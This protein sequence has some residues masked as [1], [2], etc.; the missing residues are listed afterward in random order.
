[1]EPT[2]Q[3]Q[4]ILGVPVMPQLPARLAF[5]QGKMWHAILS[6]PT[7]AV[8]ADTNTGKSTRQALRTIGAVLGKM[9]A[10][11]NDIGF[12]YGAGNAANAC[13]SRLAATLAWNLDLTHL[14]SPTSSIYSQRARVAF[15]AAY[16]TASNLMT[17]SAHGCSFEG[18]QFFAGV[19]SANPTGCVKITGTRNY[20]KHCHVAGIGND[21]N[22]IAGAYSLQ[23]DAASENFFEDCVIGLGTT[24]AGT[25]A[26]AEI[27]FK[28][29]SSRQYFKNCLIVRRIEHGTNHPLVKVTG[30]TGIEDVTIFENCG[31]VSYATNRAFRQ[32]GVFKFTATPTKGE[33]ILKDCWG[34]GADKWDV[35]DLDRITLVNTPAAPAADTAGLELLV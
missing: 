23:F 20:F 21:A 15:E 17:L 11:R 12:L 22:D 34:V 19:A 18:I 1:M 30:A 6:D 24:D 26:N 27:E 32:A 29:A 5:T 10:N 25:N 16:A 3:V 31:F 35:D 9:A 7:S 14:F 8:S 28:T 4:R 2:P 13:S 33:I